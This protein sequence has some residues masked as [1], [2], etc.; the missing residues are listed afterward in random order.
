[1]ITSYEIYFKSRFTSK[2]VYTITDLPYFTKNQWT[3]NTMHTVDKACKHNAQETLWY[4][5]FGSKS[6]WYKLSSVIV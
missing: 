1:M 2:L 4:T 3:D 5:K 6:V